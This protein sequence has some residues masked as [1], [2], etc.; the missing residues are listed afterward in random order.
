[1]RLAFLCLT[2]SI[3]ALASFGACRNES[4][5]LQPAPAV[6]PAP[7]EAAAPP[8]DGKNYSVKVAPVAL[9]TGAKTSSVLTIVG[10]PGLHFNTEF[11]ARFVVEAAAFARSTKDKLTLKDGDVKIVD[12]KGVVTIPLEGLAAGAGTLKVTGNFSVCSDEQCYILRNEVLSLAVA[13]R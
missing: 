1:M 13:V 11:P 5:A 10:A 9:Q 2:L 7:T 12:G 4:Q 6:A 3:T 8:D